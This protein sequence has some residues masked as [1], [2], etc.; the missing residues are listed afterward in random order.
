MVD[1]FG[2]ECRRQIVHFPTRKDCGQINALGLVGA[3]S[4]FTALHEYS[5]LTAEQVK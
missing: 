3:Q 2:A 4:P 5:T 1:P